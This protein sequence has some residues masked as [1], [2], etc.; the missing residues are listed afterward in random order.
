MKYDMNKKKICSNSSPT[1]KSRCKLLPFLNTLI[2][3]INSQPRLHICVPGSDW[4]SGPPVL[5]APPRSGSRFV[6]LLL[7]KHG[8]LS[9]RVGTV[10]SSALRSRA[11]PEEE[12]AGYG[13]AAAQARLIQSNTQRAGAGGGGREH[14]EETLG[15][16]GS[17]PSRRSR[18]RQRRDNSARPD[19][20]RGQ[21][22]EDCL[23]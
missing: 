11:A 18:R 17:D 2:G 3:Q 14:G 16:T 13:G 6:L 23:H 12:R 19:G 10:D 4:S 20:L 22:N 21:M 7:L 8:G 5:P 1:E 9:G 15:V